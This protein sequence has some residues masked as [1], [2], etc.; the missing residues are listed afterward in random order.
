MKNKHTKFKKQAL[1]LLNQLAN[2]GECNGIKTTIPIKAPKDIKLLGTSTK[3]EKGRKHGILTSVMYLSPHESSGF[4]RTRTGSTVNLCPFASSNCPTICLGKTSGLLRMTNT[5]NAQRWKSALYLIDRELFR[6][7]L[8]ME[9]KKVQTKAKKLGLLCAIRLNG[10]SD[11]PFERNWKFSEMFPDVQFYEY[12]KSPSSVRDLENGLNS[13]YHLTYSYHGTEKSKVVA[14]QAL[15]L[16]ASVSAIVDETDFLN[17]DDQLEKGR[18]VSKILNKVLG[19][20]RLSSIN[21]VNGDEHDARFLDMKRSLVLLKRKGGK[22]IRP[23]FGDD[24]V[25]IDNEENTA[26]DV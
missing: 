6:N 9:I 26:I 14:R 25:K 21:I 15:E 24:L 13:N 18:K 5:Q 1:K 22:R 11:L 8:I 10:T 2:T 7:L 12:T 20:D 19:Q 16:G 3:I 4:V 23:L 17:D